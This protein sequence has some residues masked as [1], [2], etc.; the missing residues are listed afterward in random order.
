MPRFILIDETTRHATYLTED[1]IRKLVDVRTNPGGYTDVDRCMAM[2]QAPADRTY[3]GFPL[4]G[5]YGQ[6]LSIHVDG[7]MD[8]PSDKGLIW[9]E[10]GHRCEPRCLLGL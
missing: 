6:A 8:F 5:Q 3:R 2:I 4:M 9:K 1:Q 7:R 10:P